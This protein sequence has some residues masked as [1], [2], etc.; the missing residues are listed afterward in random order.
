MQAGMHGLRTASKSLK[1]R[2]HVRAWI[3]C[4]RHAQAW[5]QPNSGLVAPETL[6]ILRR[7]DLLVHNRARDLSGVNRRQNSINLP[8][9]STIPLTS[10]HGGLSRPRPRN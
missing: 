7:G 2:L 4:I 9:P 10:I 3:R 6:A 1:T 5:N 8:M